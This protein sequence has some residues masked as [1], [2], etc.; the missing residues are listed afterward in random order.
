LLAAAYWAGQAY[1]T[2]IESFRAAAYDGPEPVTDVLDS[3]E[4]AKLP[5]DH[6]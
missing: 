2:M 5:I 6:E 4:Y 1:G 3:L